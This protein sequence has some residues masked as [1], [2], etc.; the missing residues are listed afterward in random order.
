VIDQVSADLPER[1]PA[2][3]AERIFKGLRNSAAKLA[4]MPVN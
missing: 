4:K 1:F 2:R 3:V